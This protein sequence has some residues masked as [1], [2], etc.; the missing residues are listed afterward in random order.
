MCSAW[1]QVFGFSMHH[2]RQHRQHL[3]FAYEWLSGGGG[4]PTLNCARPRKLC[5]SCQQADLCIFPILNFET[6]RVQ[7][8]AE[9][10]FLI[11]TTNIGG[12][13]ECVF[14]VVGFR[15]NTVD[16][17]KIWVFQLQDTNSWTGLCEFEQTQNIVI[18]N[19]D[20]SLQ[21][22]NVPSAAGYEWWSCWLWTGLD[23]K[24]LLFLLQSP[25][26]DLPCASWA[27]LLVWEKWATTG[28]MIQG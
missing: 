16:P 14:L 18:K 21:D 23:P 20:V 7:S 24:T 27:C 22:M 8:V 26:R 3:D 6:I 1:V 4:S 2:H 28:K 12:A 13:Y 17:S 9:R 11:L 25:F 10:C 15:D 19:K 5:R